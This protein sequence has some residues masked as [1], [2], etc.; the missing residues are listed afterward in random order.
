[1]KNRR[2]KTLSM[3]LGLSGILASLCV[4]AS[5]PPPLS[6]T[7]EA[8]VQ[9]PFGSP[10]A[11]GLIMDI[12]EEKRPPLKIPKVPTKDMGWRWHDQSY[13]AR[14]PLAARR[15]PAD[16]APLPHIR[17]TNSELGAERRLWLRVG[18]QYDQWLLHDSSNDIHACI[19][20]D[21]AT[22]KVYFFEFE[23]SRGG[24]WRRAGT[25]DNCYSCHP[26]GPRVIRPLAQAKVDRQVLATFNRRILSYG[27]CDFWGSVNTQ[28]LGKPLA[29]QRCLGCHD[30]AQRGRLYAIHTDPVLFKTRIERTMPPP[31]SP[32]P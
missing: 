24:Q 26:S 21:R 5:L 14:I 25:T 32:L 13:Y 27:L 29:D 8:V 11:Q 28:I 15:V 3:V 4:A 17:F 22:K 7:E 9:H 23:K 6:P 30:G 20:V 2:V 19:S 31:P 12:L 1:M 18:P 10:G 16:W